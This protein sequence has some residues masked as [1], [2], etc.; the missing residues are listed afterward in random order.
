[1]A[2][3]PVAHDEVATVVTTLEMTQRPPARP[4]PSAP[5]RL[6]RWN[7]PALAGYRALFARIGTPWLWY[8][9]LAMADAALVAIL[10][11]PAVE[12]YAVVD[13]AGIEVGMLELDRNEAGT[14]RIAYFGLIPELTGR[15]H[16]RW[17][18]AQ[19][20]ALGWRRDT[21]RM[22]VHTC[23]LDHPRALGFYRAQGFVAIAR[24]LETFPDPR[25]TGLLPA[26]AAQAVPLLAPDRRR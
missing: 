15:G 20:L 8:S 3:I 4:L 18:M 9:R 5:L 12:V 2:L 10:A 7:S 21:Q 25:L 19:T 1:M 14:C 11:D 6:V 26:D 17:L 13:P 16:G 23:T 22:L 24:T